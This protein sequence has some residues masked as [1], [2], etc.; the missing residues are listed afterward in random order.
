MLYKIFKILRTVLLI[1]LL[2]MWKTGLMQSSQI[3]ARDLQR[4]ERDSNGVVLNAG[5]FSLDGRQ[6]TCWYLIHKV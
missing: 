2:L 1:G 5:E 6:D 4:W 3:D